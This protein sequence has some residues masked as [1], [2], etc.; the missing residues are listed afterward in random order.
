MN[1]HDVQPA[2]TGWTTWHIT[3]GTYGTRLHGGDRPT[4]DRLHNQ[5]GEPFIESDAEKEDR[6]RQRMCG[7]SVYLTHNER[8]F[9]E[10]IVPTLCERGSWL[11]RTCAA[12]PDHVHVLC[13]VKAAMH[14]K[15][16]RRWLK[17][18]ASMQ[19]NAEYEL[20]TAGRWWAE[21]GSTR[22]VKDVSYLRNVTDYI[23]RQRATKA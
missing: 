4:V 19:L 9:V 20:P 8:R 3:W 16:V 1:R 14:G 15:S 18:W 5:L 11:L 2:A 7:S 21:A 22:A 12:G 17:T 6:K 13:D 10:S 23:H